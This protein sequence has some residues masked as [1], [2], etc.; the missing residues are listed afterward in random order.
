MLLTISSFSEVILL[1]FLLSQFD[2]S[3]NASTNSSS[4][5]YSELSELMILGD[6]DLDNKF[7]KQLIL[8]ITNCNNF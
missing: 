2:K 5:S 4:D 1:S 6:S 8:I 3:S 7:Y